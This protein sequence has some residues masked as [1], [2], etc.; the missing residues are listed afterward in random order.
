M[1]FVDFQKE[2]S[3][4]EAEGYR[5][6][7]YLSWDYGKS[8]ALAVEKNGERYQIPLVECFYD[9]DNEGNRTKW[10]GV[11][12]IRSTPWSKELRGTIG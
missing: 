2:I 4:I 7:K 11:V 8:L 9:T 5:I 10:H 6:V 1:D 3:A 12:D